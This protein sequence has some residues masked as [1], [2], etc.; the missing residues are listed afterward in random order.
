MQSMEHYNWGSYY[1]FL[2]DHADKSTT[3]LTGYLRAMYPRLSRSEAKT[4]IE[5]WR[6]NGAAARFL[7]GTEA[8]T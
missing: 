6:G 1:S 2:D 7:D 3:T 5:R 8:Y 4:V